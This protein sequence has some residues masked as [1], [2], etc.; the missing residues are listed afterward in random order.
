M[1]T[2]SLRTVAT[3][4]VAVYLRLSRDDSN[5]NLESMS[6]ANQRDFLL[7]YAEERGWKVFDI[8]I[9]DGYS[10]T[11]FERPGF[12]RMIADIEAG[13]INL[14]L[15]KDLSRLGRN[16]VQ[17]GQYTDFY[18]PSKGVRYVAVNDNVDT[19]HDENDIAPFKNI[20]NEMY[21]RDISRKIRSSRSV[22]AKQGKFMGSKAPYG[23][24]KSVEN[25]HLLVI[26][27][28]PA[29]V[30]RRIF[31]EFA[32]GDSGRNIATRLNNENVDTPAVYYHK[33]TG[34][35]AT[36]GDEQK[37]G[38]STIMQLLK[39]QVYI[40]H[41]VQGKRQVA[42][43]KTKQRQFIPTEDWIVVEDTQEPIVDLDI[44]NRVQARLETTKAAPSN[45]AVRINS[46]GKVNL[47]SGIIRCA[48]CGS[49]M[50]FNRKVYSGNERIIYR[51]GRY[52]NS[53]KDQCSSHS[54]KQETLEQVI[55]EDMRHYAEAAVT[56]ENA[57]I[58]RLLLA[59]DRE[60]ERERSAKRQAVTKLQKRIDTIDRMVKQ[61]FEEKVAGSVPLPMFK[62]LL[63]DYEQ[64]RN[65]LEAQ[66]RELEM[67]M[68][69]ATDTERD[70]MAWMNL[71]KNS[72]SLESLDR[73][74]AFRLIDNISVS[75]K[76]EENGKKHQSIAIQYNFV[77]CLDC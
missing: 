60:R 14:V 39:N 54:I 34:K 48:D 7:N 6:I 23:Y 18:F 9:D 24:V 76:F 42:S 26:D 70:V 58:S 55:L 63:A 40:G 68:Q 28:F 41:M 43:F 74:T 35:R 46:T 59:T 44:W 57:L 13:H 2:A 10:G 66:I 8:Y 31:R 37:W 29:E 73:E 61:L 45:H 52:A 64:E 38:S 25:K 53:G 50:A 19:S 30:I 12:N 75:E 47:F 22:S 33:Q 51:C 56:D 11:T 1:R 36:R 4:V 15:T 20:L 69:T 67:G 17:T 62:K 5:G 77:G 49:A 21:A 27:P 71:I 65:G 72:L 16:Y 32:F 3:I